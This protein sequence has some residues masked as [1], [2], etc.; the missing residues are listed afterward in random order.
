MDQ[1]PHR[2]HGEYERSTDA[3]V[4]SAVCGLTAKTLKFLLQMNQRVPETENFGWR[5]ANLALGATRKV[6]SMKKLFWGTS[7]LVLSL[8][9]GF[10][11]GV[12]PLAPSSVTPK[13]V[14]PEAAAPKSTSA[15]EAPRSPRSP[16]GNAPINPDQPNLK[17][18]AIVL[19]KT[20]AEIQE[21]GVPATNGVI[22]HDI[23]FLE[24][25]DF[26]K[27]INPFIGK[28]LT[29]NTIRDLEDSI[30]LYC[31][32][33]GKLLVDVI[34]P[35]QDIGNGVLQLWF[36]E[37]K[38]GKIT[39]NN[40]DRKWF[41]DKLILGDVRLQS[42]EPI[43]SKK[44]TEDLDWLNNNPFRQV[45][46]TFKPGDQLGSSDVELE[47]NDR[48]P[49]RPY[50]GIENSGT[51]FTGE[52]RFLA[53]FNWGNVFGL[54]QQLNYQFA[55]DINFELVKA[56]SASYIIPLPWRHTLMLYG[57]YVDGK[58]D[59]SPIGLG[60]TGDGRS[61]QTSLRY[62]IPLPE[63]GHFRHEVSAGFDFKRANNDL[64]AGGVT[65]LQTSDTDIAQFEL[66]YSGLLADSYGRTTFGLE[67]YYAPGGW[68]EYNNDT[69]FNNLRTDA[70]ASYFYA[71]LNAERLTRL[72]YGFSWV[73]AGW[74]QGATERLLPSEEL[75]LGGYNTVRGYDERVVSGDNG[76]IVNNELRTPPLSPGDLLHMPYLRD[77]LQFLAFFDYGAVRVIDA[78]PADGADPNKTLYSVGMGFRYTVRKNLSVRFDYGWALTEK[79]INENPSRA[80][81]G[82]LASF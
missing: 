31:R 9:C 52:N 18:T 46:V 29:E 38:V 67:A 45:D 15:T 57:S 69:D 22:I 79:S 55:A 1:R 35:E 30:I 17:I 20:R 76:W 23:P 61:W 71:R 19:V 80:M 47:V 70:K 78:V 60:T 5:S 65:V 43:D 51:R 33:R 40:P 59:F 4:K 26:Q 54:D 82:I 13:P 66:G 58:A 12:T 73:L 41:K 42:G 39:V 62:S 75:A 37:G 48:I 44:L 27:A 2:R 24:T 36:L 10:A 49:V 53:G 56:N 68:T 74:L 7:C 6:S 8:C 64:Q 32:A 21:G 11:Q 28:L 72:P 50:L 34:L 63:I 14:Q 25:P 3:Q 77:E 16:E 81:F